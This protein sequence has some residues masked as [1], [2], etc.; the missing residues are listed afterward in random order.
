MLGTGVRDQIIEQKMLLATLLPRKWCSVRSVPGG[1]VETEDVL[2]ILVT[3]PITVIKCL[4]KQFKGG[5]VLSQF[6]TTTHVTG[7]AW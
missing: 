1:G 7:K 5:F 2:F 4:A 6:V 3:V